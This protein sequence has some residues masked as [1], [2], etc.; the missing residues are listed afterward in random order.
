MKT[1]ALLLIALFTLSCASA[2]LPDGTEVT[3]IGSGSFQT[4]EVLVESNGFSDNFTA[5]FQ[6]LIQGALAF[7]G[8]GPA[9]VPEVN[10]AVER[11]V[12]ADE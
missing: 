4:E 5:G 11:V 9:V 12:E 10:V 7:F 6:R 3:V 8:R 1:T 2:T